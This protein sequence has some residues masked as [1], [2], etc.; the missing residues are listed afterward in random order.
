MASGQM[1]SID[2]SSSASTVPMARVRL[3]NCHASKPMMAITVSDGAASSTPSTPDS[4]LSIGART[5][6]KKGRKCATTQPRPWLIQLSSGS[7][8]S[9][10]CVR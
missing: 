10:I 8:P 5:A 2:T 4:T 7:E 6:W 1:P 3:V 9:K